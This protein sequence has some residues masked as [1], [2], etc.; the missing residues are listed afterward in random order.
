MPECN[1]DLLEVGL[2]T[3]TEAKYEFHNWSSFEAWMVDV[4]LEVQ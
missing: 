4:Q 1:V 3:E 2:A